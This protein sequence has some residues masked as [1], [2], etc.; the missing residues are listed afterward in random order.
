MANTPIKH[1]G[2]FYEFELTNNQAS[3]ANIDNFLVN[4]DR[5][6]TF[7]ADYSIKRQLPG[8]PFVTGV[9]DTDFATAIGTGADDTVYAVYSEPTSGDIVI[10]GQFD[11]FNGNGVSGLVRLDD[12]GAEDAT[13]SGN[14][15]TGFNNIVVSAVIQPDGKVIVGGNFTTLNGVACLM[16]VRLNADG[17]EDTTFTTNI[18]T[19]PSAVVRELHLQSDGKILVGIN[20]GTFNGNSCSGLVRLNTDGTEDTAFTTNLGTGFND[21]VTS[22]LELGDGSIMVGGIFTTLNGGAIADGLVKLSSAGVLD[23]TFDT[24]LGTGFSSYVMEIE[25]QADGKILVGGE[26][27]TFNGNARTY[28]VRLNANGTEDT[29][30]YTNLISTGNNAGFSGSVQGLIIQDDGSLIVSGNFATLNGATVG[31]TVKLSEDG[32][33]NS[34]FS[35]NLG[36]GFDALV[37][38][39]AITPQKQILIG[40]VFT[41]FNGNTRNRVA[42][43][44]APIAATTDTIQQ[45]TIRGIY[46]NGTGWEL[47]GPT[48]VGD[49]A[50]IV[51]SITT[52]GQMQYT[53]TNIPNL[54]ANVMRF[55]ITGM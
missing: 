55:I 2:Q 5:N 3:P 24:N 15:G 33:V 30:F 29:T 16:L 23:S 37:F 42:M 52:D 14:L 53:S 32:I 18:G 46:R 26:Y 48:S 17:T 25:E 41:D 12:T 31:R 6:H 54:V 43:L 38:S 21:N 7:F 36:T 50:G 8:G 1:F 11:N 27:S 49:D 39:T 22:L 28:L 34:S 13:F 20:N 19:G 35:T 10:S 45:G 44:A 4:K 51:F 47:H 9:E 40:G